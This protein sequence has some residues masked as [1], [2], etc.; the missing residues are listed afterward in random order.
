LPLARVAFERLYS[1]ESRAVRYIRH[2]KSM[3]S[4]IAGV[5]VFLG[6]CLDE[7]WSRT[8]NASIPSAQDSASDAGPRRVGVHDRNTARRRQIVGENGDGGID[9]A[10]Q[11]AR[12]PSSQ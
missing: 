9:V 11:L 1:P 5:G 3:A 4:M 10:G 2:T 6:E 7:A 12:D 8:P